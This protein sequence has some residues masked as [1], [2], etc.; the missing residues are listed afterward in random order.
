[1]TRLL[2]ALILLACHGGAFW[3]W[4]YFTQ[5]EASLN[6]K[7][8]LAN[9]SADDLRKGYHARRTWARF[10]PWLGL[11]VCGCIPVL[12]G[13]SM[14]AF[15]VS[16]PSL[17]ILLG[18]YFARF[19]TPALNLARGKAEFYASPDSASW[20]DAAAWKVIRQQRFAADAAEQ[21]AAND[22]LK[23]RLES[24]WLWGRLGYAVLMAATL[25]L[26]FIY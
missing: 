1:M 2:L 13:G 3:A 15:V 9:G 24:A 16:Y 10:W 8:I 18:A 25:F 20:P 7:D 22:N 12:I 26:L 11:T 19:F 23:G 17:G 14:S 6:A 5:R 4:C 21:Q